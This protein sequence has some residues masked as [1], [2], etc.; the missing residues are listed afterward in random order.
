M[1]SEQHQI[2][3]RCHYHLAGHSEEVI[4]YNTELLSGLSKEI[5]AEPAFPLYLH[6][7][8][9]LWL[10]HLIMKVPKWFPVLYCAELITN[11]ILQ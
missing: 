5:L 9:S 6:V 2:E 4:K 11:N 3:V 7:I 1:H 10:P 8:L